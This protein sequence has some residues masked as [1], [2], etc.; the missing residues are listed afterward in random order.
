MTRGDVARVCGNVGGN[1]NIGDNGVNVCGNVTHYGKVGNKS[2]VGNAS[3][4]KDG[5]G[6][7]STDGTPV[8]KGAVDIIKNDKDGS[9]DKEKLCRHVGRFMEE[10]L[11]IGN[12]TRPDKLDTKK[13]SQKPVGDC[14]AALFTFIHNDG[15]KTKIGN[16]GNTVKH[17]RPYLKCLKSGINTARVGDANEKREKTETKKLS[18]KC[19]KINLNKDIPLAKDVGTTILTC[20]KHLSDPLKCKRIKIATVATSAERITNVV[21]KDNF[22]LKTC[23]EKTVDKTQLKEKEKLSKEM[24][25]DNSILKEVKLTKDLSE[26]LV[27]KKVNAV[28]F[29]DINEIKK[30]NSESIETSNIYT[31]FK[32]ENRMKTFNSNMLVSLL[33]K[34]TTY[35]KTNLQHVNKNTNN[36]FEPNTVKM[37]SKLPKNLPQMCSTDFSFKPNEKKSPKNVSIGS[38]YESLVRDTV[39][40]DNDNDFSIPNDNIINTKQ[41]LKISQ[42]HDGEKQTPTMLNNNVGSKRKLNETIEKDS[43][44]MQDEALKN[45]RKLDKKTPSINDGINMNTDSNSPNKS[46]KITTLVNDVGDEGKNCTENVLK[47][48]EMIDSESPTDVDSKKKSK[49]PALPILVF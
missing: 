21:I 31:D 6:D 12:V 42:I 36:I 37:K 19:K 33:T 24:A 35:P 1:V 46:K 39:T 7:S 23:H 9:T 8:G 5:D 41:N 15:G 3:V 17:N 29:D 27:A 48:N 28:T 45:K 20:K 13:D 47:S 16:V 11:V 34:E 43:S 32:V 26:F 49:K 38:L 14:N 22:D 30:T 18:L 44:T 25:S 40:D 4:V 10:K 2:T